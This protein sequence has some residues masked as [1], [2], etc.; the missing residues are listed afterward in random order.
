MRRFTE[1]INTGTRQ[2]CTRAVKGLVLIHLFN[3]VWRIGKA[4]YVKGKLHSIIYSP[5]DKEYHVWGKDVKSFYMMYNEEYQDYCESPISK[6]DPAKVKIYILTHILDE[7]ENWCFDM[8]K[9]PEIGKSVKVIF[10]NGTIKWTEP[11]TGDWKNHRMEIPSE[12]MLGSNPEWLKSLGNIQRD[13]DGKI[14]ESPSQFLW[15]PSTEYKN[16]VA[17]RIK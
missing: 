13:K 8:N 4:K 3:K 5:E 17:W 9:T 11:F 2:E 14:K 6:P 10:T 16:I 7:K 15:E 1:V 12:R